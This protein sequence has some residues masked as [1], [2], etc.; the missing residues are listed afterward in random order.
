MCF[1]RNVVETSVKSVRVRLFAAAKVLL[2]RSQ[3][4]VPVRKAGLL[5]RLVHV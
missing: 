5:Q 1:N 4:W 3:F 2:D